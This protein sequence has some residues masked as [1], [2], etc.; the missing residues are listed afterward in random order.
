MKSYQDFCKSEDESTE[1]IKPA[2]L[3]RRLKSLGYD[4]KKTRDGNLYGLKI[5]TLQEDDTVVKD[6][7]NLS[8]EEIEAMLAD[9]LYEDQKIERAGDC[10]DVV[11]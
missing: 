8:E 9:D 11:M 3:S 6:Y 4:H 10:D 1:F 7:A 5:I 2:D